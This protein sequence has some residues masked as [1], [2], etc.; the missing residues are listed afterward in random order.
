ML[1]SLNDEQIKGIE[2]CR[3]KWIKIGLQTGLI[4]RDAA[5]VAVNKAYKCAGLEPPRE[6]VF[7]SSP[8]DMDKKIRDQVT[9]NITLFIVTVLPT[10][11]RIG[12]R[13]STIFTP[14]RA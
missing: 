11:G 13:L 1:N 6:V 10:A 8:M 3:A 12:W 14:T 4:D 5:I 2:V 9:T 7:C